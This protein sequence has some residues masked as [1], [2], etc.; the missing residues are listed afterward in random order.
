M[1][2][3]LKVCVWFDEKGA[4]LVSETYGAGIKR[5]LLYKEKNNRKE[6]FCSY[7]DYVEDSN[8]LIEFC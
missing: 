6:C 7:I 3:F 5:A 2:K 1:T 8:E 4:F